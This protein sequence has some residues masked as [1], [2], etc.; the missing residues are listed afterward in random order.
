M[1]AFHEQD[2]T[3]HVQDGTLHVTDGSIGRDLFPL[4]YHAVLPNPLKALLIVVH[5]LSE[6]KGRYRRLQR[7]LASEGYGT[8]AYDQRGFGLSGGARTYVRAHTDFLFDLKKVFEFVRGRHPGLKVALMGHSFGGA[9]AAS[10]CAEYPSEA[11]GLALSA[12]AYKVPS[13]P[14][15]LE[16][17]GYLLNHLMPA[18]AIRYQSE[19]KYLSRDPEIGAAFRSDPLVQQAGTPRFYIE[20]RKM[21]RRLRREAEKI[22]VP[23]LILQGTED[24]IVIPQGAQAL[25][26]R[27][28]TPHK[29]LIW[30][31]GFYHEV[32]NEIGRE[33]VI[34]DLI[35]WLK[36][37]IA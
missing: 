6:H 16:L 32:F 13:L 1:G 8:Y 14:L 15:R 30:Y 18:R 29:R 23:T 37:Y 19:P 27:L 22:A 33:R 10:F 4:S 25:Y 34:A 31:E 28:T 5:G 21:N 2:G 3:L 20:F 17:L 7:D 24:R 26:N 11:D 36:E 9:V 35:S 12:P